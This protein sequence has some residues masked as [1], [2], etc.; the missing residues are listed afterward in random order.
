MFADNDYLPADPD[1]PA[2]IAELRPE[3]GA[4]QGQSHPAGRWRATNC[5]NGPRFIMRCSDEIALLFACA[6]ADARGARRPKPIR[7]WST[8]R[9]KEGAVV[10][11][12]AMIVNQIVRPMVEAFEAK[13]PGIKVQYSRADRLDV[14]L[15]IMQRGARAAACRPICSTAPTRCSC[16]WRPGWWREYRPKAAQRIRRNCKDPDGLLDRAEHLFY[17]TA[18]YNTNLVTAADAPKTYEDLLDPKWKGKIAWTYDLTPGGP[19]GFVHNILTHRW[20]RKRAW[21]I[22]G[23]SRSRSR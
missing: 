12:S 14:A 8:R 21:R 23:H 13:Y 17:W 2:R 16:C 11:Y 10:W 5:R 9:K 20:G 15:K 3:A 19:P 6:A 7:R 18:A 22:C 1:V 4:F